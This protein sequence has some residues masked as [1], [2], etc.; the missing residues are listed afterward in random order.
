MPYKETTFPLVS[1]QRPGGV[2]TDWMG[3]G[4]DTIPSSDTVGEYHKVYKIC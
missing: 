1:G 4:G 3:L 2:F